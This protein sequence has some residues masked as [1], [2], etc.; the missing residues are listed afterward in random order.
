MNLSKSL[1]KKLIIILGV[2]LIVF[3]Q[4][5][6]LFEKTSITEL[7]GMRNEFK[8]TKVGIVS[9]VHSGEVGYYN[10]NIYSNG[11]LVIYRVK[12][13]I[14]YSPDAIG[15]GIFPSLEEHYTA[16]S[17]PWHVYASE[18]ERVLFNVPYNNVE[19]ALNGYTP[20]YASDNCAYMFAD[21]VNLTSVDF[22]DFNFF[23]YYDTD[24]SISKA[25]EI[26]RDRRNDKFTLV[27]SV[28]IAHT[29]NIEGMFYNCSS[30]NTISNLDYNMLHITNMSNMF[31]GCSSLTELDFSNWN[32]NSSANMQS[33][34]K[35]TTALS[36]LDLG[37]NFKFIRSGLGKEALILDNTKNWTRQTTGTMYTAY[38]LETTYNGSTMSDTYIASSSRSYI[39]NYYDGETYLGTSTHEIDTAQNLRPY[40]GTSPTG[41]SFAGWGITNSTTNVTYTDGQSVTNLTATGGATIN[42]YAIHKRTLTLA[43]NGNGSTSGSTTSQTG[44]QYYNINGTV[45]TVDFIVKNNGFNKTGYVWNTWNTK[46]NGTGTDYAALSTYSMAPSYNVTATRY[47]Q[48]TL[49]AQWTE[50]TYNVV[51]D[52]GSATTNGTSTIYEVFKNNF[53]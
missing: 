43:Y 32:V 30:L 12:S 46:I 28:A 23:H 44:T 49:Y 5:L 33:M 3:S 31:N 13:D 16:D 20:V 50:G 6:I 22:N 29:T 27:G 11:D 48:S 2:I 42:L 17:W 9:S 41:W 25:N 53:Y 21:M 7:E 26:L 14:D 37:G 45:T 36:R 10:W 51:L 8:D 35:N 15:S 40:S 24:T 47:T 34:L 4:F 52:N 18:V 38:N 39:V 1:K 19:G